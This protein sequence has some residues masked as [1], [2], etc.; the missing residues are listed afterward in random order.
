VERYEA[1]TEAQAVAIFEKLIKKAREEKSGDGA[2]I[3]YGWSYDSSDFVELWGR[4]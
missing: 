4:W 1:I 3:S 2:R